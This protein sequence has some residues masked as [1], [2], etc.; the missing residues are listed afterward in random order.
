[1]AESIPRER[2]EQAVNR[3][4]E[5][6]AEWN[7]WIEKTLQKAGKESINWS[8]K[9]DMEGIDCLI[10]E[11]WFSRL[12]R[13]DRG[14]LKLVGIYILH[15]EL[16]RADLRDSDLTDA[17]LMNANLGGA[18]LNDARLRK[19]TLVGADL[20]NAKMDGATLEMANLEG[21]DLTGATLTNADLSKADLTRAVL[22]KVD[23][24]LAKLN[25]ARL[26]GTSVWDVDLSD[27]EQESMVVTPSNEPEFSVDY[28][29][30]A[31]FMYTI[32]D[33]EKI[34]LV[35]DS[36]TTKG[37]LI[38]GRFTHLDFLKGLKERLRR[39]G[40]LPMLFDFK[41]PERKTLIDTVETMAKL[42]RFIIGDFTDPKII[43][44]EFP[45]VLNNTKIPF[46]P[47]IHKDHYDDNVKN[48]KKWSEGIRG[49]DPGLPS[50]LGDYPEQ[51]NL[52][53]A[54]VY[55]EREDF[56]DELVSVIEERVIPVEEELR[57]G[58]LQVEINLDRNQAAL[59]ISN[60]AE[61]LEIT[62]INL[63]TNEVHRGEKERILVPGEYVVT[64]KDSRAGGKGVAVNF[65]V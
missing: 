47:V 33:N 64:V 8:S 46:L 25:E 34:R 23:F 22:V 14:G 12:G 43:L 30:V 1:M 29:E 36:S 63:T 60:E 3:G 65:K 19:A 55:D 37:V 52:V 15:A 48:S 57:L 21:A 27:C 4:E 28:L 18:R 61:P 54:V 39:L 40:F 59:R 53:R 31:Q 56:L 24:R 35:L 20:R 44:Q 2:F 6:A 42:C 16:L 49:Y 13:T 5:G 38:L 45:A 26:Y 51:R 62:W 7:Q 50:T 11:E 9:S 41:K 58:P 32:L 17:N 10:S